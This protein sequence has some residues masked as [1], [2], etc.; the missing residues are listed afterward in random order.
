MQPRLVLF[1][2]V[3]NVYRGARRTFFDPTR[4]AHVCG[5]FDP[6]KMGQIIAARS[7]SSG[8]RTLTGVRVYTGQPDSS[9][10]PKGYGA[11]R[12]QLAAW[13]TRGATVIKRTLRYPHDWPSRKP[14]EKGIDVK[15]AV[16]FVA[17]AINGDYDVGV[18]VSADTDLK[19]ALEFVV[20]GMGGQCIAEVAAWREP[21]RRCPRLDIRGHKIWCH[22]MTRVDYDSMADPRNYARS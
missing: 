17:M 21:G 14:E 19:P 1:I 18:I 6:L 13:Q 15:L 10:D 2:D 7:S 11:K 12:K 16:D 20:A 3:Q 22:W 4:D 8:T 9:K 5:Q